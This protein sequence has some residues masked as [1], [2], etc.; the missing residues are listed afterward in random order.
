M[1]QDWTDVLNRTGLVLGFFSFWLAA[2]EFIGEARLRSWELSLAK[3]LLKVPTVLNV[4]WLLIIQ[5]IVGVYIWKV[6]HTGSLFSRSNKP[7][8]V[9]VVILDIVLFTL[10]F[11]E[12]RIPR[13]VAVMAN[14]SK[15]R[16]R[17]FF[18]GAVLFTLSF[19]MQLLATFA[20]TK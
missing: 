14:D 12:K 6:W 18:I 16:Q 19:L 15:I 7:P 17:S 2:P 1:T 13:L 20:P 9:L 10:S 4:I 11:S 8:F 3:G 5:A